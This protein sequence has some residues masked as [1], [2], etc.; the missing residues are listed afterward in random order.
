MGEER[1]K[2]LI[3]NARDAAEGMARTCRLARQHANEGR[4]CNATMFVDG[5]GWQL[6]ILEVYGE[7]SEGLTSNADIEAFYLQADNSIQAVESYI[8]ERGV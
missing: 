1:N 8:E 4:F 7:E 5:A 2:I 6:A 3:A